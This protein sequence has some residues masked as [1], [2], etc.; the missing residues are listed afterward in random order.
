MYGRNKM[1]LRCLLIGV[2]ILFATGILTTQSYAKID[3]KTI[4]ASWL[5]DEGTGN[6]AK[7]S[8]GN[9]FDGDLHGNVKWVDGKFGKGLEFHGD[10]L[11]ADY[12][13]IRNS[14]WSLDFG[15]D[16]PF[17]ITTWV[18]YQQN[19]GAIVNKWN[20]Y[21]VGS[22]SLDCSETV[23]FDRNAAPGHLKGNIALT[24]GKFEHVA[25]TYDGKEMKIYVNGK[26]DTKQKANTQ[27]TDL[28]TPVLIGA[29]FLTGKPMFFFQGILDEVILFDYALEENQIVEVMKGMSNVGVTTTLGLN[30]AEA[31][32]GSQFTTQLNINDATGV[33]SGDITIKYDPNILSVG[34][35]KT[36]PLTSG[37]TLITN[38]SVLGQ[39]KIAMAGASA[40]PSGSGSLIGITFTVN[41]KASAGAETVIQ[42]TDTQLY[43]ELAEPIQISLENGVVRIKQTCIKGDV[44]NDGNIRSNDATLILRIVAGLLVPN[45]YQKCAADANND[46]QIRSNDATIVL[47]KAAGLGAP[48]KDL[49]ANRHINI[50]LSESHGLKGEIISVPI[51]IDNIDVLSSGDMSINYDSKVLR[52][53]DV[54]SSDDLLMADNISQPGLIRISFAGI[55][56]LNDGKL[57]EI[58]FEVL[59]DEVSPLTF[60]L[61]EFYGTD[62]LPLNSRVINKQ[63][64][65]WAVAPER[66]ALLQ[67]YPNP[68][69]PETWIPYQLKDDSQVTIQI[70]SAS[71]VLIRRL[72]LGYKSS[73]MYTSPDRSA[74]WNGKNEAGEKVSSGLYFYTIQAGNYSS[75]MKMI[76]TK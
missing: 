40:I 69:N 68:F 75:T 43:N 29:R 59:T 61:A 42:L 44:N 67:N 46:G 38:T 26:L 4:I 37:M 18:N 3:P 41:P 66:S 45:D 13:Q 1:K 6:V 74:Y 57:A 34:D 65:S 22:Y 9:G 73:G 5:F 49:I 72:E 52:V 64:R 62:A 60:K 24:A 11:S 50:S 71:G 16:T 23:G 10:A 25:A 7:D 35:T 47:R 76:V 48:S 2:I 31:S 33:S 53:I 63:F 36:T 58:K 8:S 39:I 17:S 54:L 32:P 14:E 55:D 21:V 70:Y 56:R 28:V 20:G 30:S 19:G 12:V 27:L 15:G 51:T